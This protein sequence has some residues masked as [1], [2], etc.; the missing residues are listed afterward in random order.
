[1]IDHLL[2]GVVH[3]RMKRLAP[4]CKKLGINYAPAM[5]GFEVRGRN[6]SVP[7][8]DGVVIHED[9]EDIVRE[10]YAVAEE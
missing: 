8:I 2:Q 6:G 10:A 1:M 3:L 5:A 9:N 4:V 7:V